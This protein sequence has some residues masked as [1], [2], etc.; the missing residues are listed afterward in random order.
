[1]ISPVLP[2]RLEKAARDNGFDLELAAA[3][4]WLAFGSTHAPINIWL[5]STQA[6]QIATAFSRSDVARA[7]TDFGEAVVADLPRGATDCLDVTTVPELYRLLRRAYQLARTLPNE[8]LREFEQRTESLPRAT[9][10]E[11]LV[12]QRVGQD[13]FRAGLMEYWEG[14][15]A[16]TGLAS[17]D[18]LR[19]SHIKPWA[20]C[21]TDAERLD[22]FNGLL[23]APHLD[24]AFDKGLITFTD[25][26]D[27]LV[28][29]ALP[30]A[31]RDVLGL[32]RSI[33]LRSISA[34]HAR[35]LQWHREKLFKT[36]ARFGKG[37]GM[38]ART[39]LPYFTY[40][41]FKPGEVSHRQLQPLLAASPEP[42]VANGLVLLRDGLPMLDAERDDECHGF[43]LRFEPAR[44]AEAYALVGAMEPGSQ[45]RWDVATLRSP[46]ERA[47]LL[48]A[49]KPNRGSDPMEASTWTSRDD[50]LFTSLL[51]VVDGVV[52]RDGVESREWFT[53]NGFDWH[54]FF[55]LQAAYLLLWSAIER[56]TALRYGAWRD[57]ME[58]IKLLG[59]EPA[60]ADALR[61]VAPEP[62]SVFDSRDPDDRADL[63]ADKPS[64]SVRYYYQVRSNLSHRGK[65]AI[66][67]GETVRSSLAELLAVFR[68]ILTTT[69]GVG[70]GS[71]K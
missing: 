15:C 43:L 33:Q 3:G 13:V 58:R 61:A 68:S 67:D 52:K 55:R 45:Y 35:Y 10:A 20:D 62:R 7:L 48:H 26:G 16:V 60:F 54:R 27:C 2:T 5:R 32:D 11:R 51:E 70:D 18:L 29:G 17:P 22:V 6:G 69:L 31:A 28:S 8:L 41:V 50:P 40:G 66:R 19:A 12:V 44:A 23:L 64:R 30:D 4:A 24:A 1:M 34:A 37:A 9:E 39:D 53:R 42:A 49:R 36:P 21:Q 65:G 57:P 63:D 14:A 59:E 47:N 71:K 38:P 56:F 25:E 46:P